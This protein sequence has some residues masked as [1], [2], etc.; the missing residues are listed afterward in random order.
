[1]FRYGSRAGLAV[2]GPRGVLACTESLRAADDRGTVEGVVKSSAGRPLPGAFVK[3][4][5]AQRRLTFLVITQ[6]QGR[7]TAADLPPGTYT[8]QAVGNGFESSWS[9]PVE[10]AAGKVAK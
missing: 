7:Y 1:M 8:A 10:V 5:N 3:L 2:I 4:K 6:E 9:A